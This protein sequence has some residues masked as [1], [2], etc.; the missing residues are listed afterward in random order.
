MEPQSVKFFKIHEMGYDK[1]Q[2]V[3]A[4]DVIAK[5]GYRD[6]FQLPSDIKP[7]TYILRVDQLSLHGNGRINGPQ[8]YT[9]CFNLEISGNGTATPPGV[10]FP[11][12]YGKNEPGVI[13]GIGNRRAFDTYVRTIAGVQN[14]CIQS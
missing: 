14:T 7:G 10:T 5:Q 8:F 9:H 1:T 4:N 6:Y 11:G 13:M 2:H 3:W 12:G